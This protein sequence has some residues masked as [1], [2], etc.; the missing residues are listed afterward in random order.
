M[1]ET[2]RVELPC[3]P[4][5]KPSSVVANEDRY[6]LKAVVAKVLPGHDTTISGCNATFPEPTIEASRGDA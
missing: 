5:L 6:D 2:F 4:V 1:P 3:H